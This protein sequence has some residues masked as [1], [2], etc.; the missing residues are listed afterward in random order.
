MQLLCC[1][2]HV[3]SGG[4]SGRASARIPAQLGGPLWGATEVGICWP[5]KCLLSTPTVY[6]N[7]VR[8][9][10]I[11]DI[12]HP[13]LQDTNL[14]LCVLVS[15]AVVAYASTICTWEPDQCLHDISAVA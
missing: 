14:L 1:C 8:W 15:K 9:H 3:D 12:Q 6:R 13:A 7:N 4:E 2:R 5:T 10:G 11:Y